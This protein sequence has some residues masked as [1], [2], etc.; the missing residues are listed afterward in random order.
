MESF[1]ISKKPLDIIS[2]S[3]MRIRLELLTLDF[4]GGG[5][6]FQ[7]NATSV[8]TVT[9]YISNADNTRSLSNGATYGGTTNLGEPTLKFGNKGLVL[10][11][12]FPWFKLSRLVSE[13]GGLSGYSE[14]FS[15]V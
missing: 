3:I 5:S 7:P 8:L 12:C 9:Q 1:R 15:N 10:W 13:R 4:Y 11:S 6:A 14:L 2:I